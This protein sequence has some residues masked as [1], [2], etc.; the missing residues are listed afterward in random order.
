MY[1]R[2]PKDRIGAAIGPEGSVKRE[3]ESR[4]GVKLEFDSETGQVNIE[5]GDNP[6]G[7]LAASDV[8]KAIA[9]GFSP[10]KAFRLFEEDQYLDLI[11]IRDYIGESD[12]AVAR[13][14]GRIIGKGGKARQTIEQ[15]TGTYISIYGRTV[16]MIGKVEQLKVVRKA[17]EMLLGGAE[18]ST[19]YKFLEKKRKETKSAP[20]F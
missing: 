18:H 6:I 20:G 2:M 11:D 12:R 1:L 4:A 15:T 19:V 14:K 9:R 10:E 3:I 8:L 5:K 17:L 7:V 13:I 16:G